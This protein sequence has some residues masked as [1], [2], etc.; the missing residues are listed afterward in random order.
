VSRP[1]TLRVTGCHETSILPLFWLPP[2]CFQNSNKVTILKGQS[3]S[4]EEK[5]R[6]PAVKLLWSRYWKYMRLLKWNL[7]A[8]LAAS[9]P[10]SQNFCT[11]GCAAFQTAWGCEGTN[12]A[13]RQSDSR[14]IT[15]HTSASFCMLVAAE[16][17]CCEGGWRNCTVE[18]RV[19]S[20]ADVEGTQVISGDSL[21]A[22]LVIQVLTYGSLVRGCKNAVRSKLHLQLSRWAVSI[23]CPHSQHFLLCILH[24]GC[25]CQNRCWFALAGSRWQ[26]WTDLTNLDM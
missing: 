16:G 13:G 9:F 1:V 18:I 20:Q 2:R 4:L 10:A 8:L 19:R 21:S 6:D 25:A 11:R 23:S 5:A 17:F 15:L 14:A 12:E 3:S 7:C 22:L 26:A 24:S